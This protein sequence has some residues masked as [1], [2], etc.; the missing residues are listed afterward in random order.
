[1]RQHAPSHLQG[2]V[3]KALRTHR[4]SEEFIFKDRH[5]RFSLGSASLRRTQNMGL[6]YLMAHRRRLV[7]DELVTH[8]LVFISDR[9][10]RR[11]TG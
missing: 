1:M 5:P 9:R 8:N 2:A 3:L 10:D 11:A 4:S 6:V 7:S